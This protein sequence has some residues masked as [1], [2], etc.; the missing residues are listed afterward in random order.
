M[1][2]VIHSAYHNLAQSTKTIMENEQKGA[3]AKKKWEAKVD[4]VLEEL[5]RE[6]ASILAARDN[7]SAQQ[8]AASATHS[9]AAQAAKKKEVKRKRRK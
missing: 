5:N 1:L 2:S 9:N 7:P 6:L 8:D 4:A 3:P